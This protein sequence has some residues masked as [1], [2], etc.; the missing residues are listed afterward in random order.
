MALNA[1]YLP[2]P[3]DVYWEQTTTHK[4]VQLWKKF[5]VHILI[6]SLSMFISTPVAFLQIFKNAGFVQSI[7][8]GSFLNQIPIPNSWGEYIKSYIIPLVIVCLNTFL[9][10]VISA[11][12][13]PLVSESD[14]GELDDILGLLQLFERVFQ[15]TRLLRFQS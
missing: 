6:W 13:K 12:S 7:L 5:S 1:S 8:Q 2:D 10:I 4:S 14:L 3:I 15:G 11:I 9:L